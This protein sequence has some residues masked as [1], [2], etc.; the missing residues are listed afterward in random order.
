MPAD[1]HPNT[2]TKAC[3]LSEAPMQHP[4]SARCGRLWI[5]LNTWTLIKKK[6]SAN[7]RMPRTEPGRPIN[8]LSNAGTFRDRRSLDR[9]SANSLWQSTRLTRCWT[10]R[11]KR[12]WIKTWFMN[13]K[14]RRW[15][16]NQ[17]LVLKFNLCT[18]RDVFDNMCEFHKAPFSSFWLLGEQMHTHTHRVTVLAK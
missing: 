7:S 17:L 4:N 10:F 18:P 16:K 15:A 11:S 12:K 1:T 8:L 14:W 5:I 13:E 2:P 6:A 3:G 9:K